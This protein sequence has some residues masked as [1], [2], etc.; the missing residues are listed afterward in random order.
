MRLLVAGD[1]RVDAGKTTFSTGLCASLDA[2]GFKPRAANDYWFDH[3][4]YRRSVH[5]GRLYG[6]DAR[7]LAAAGPGDRTPEDCNPVHRLWR[8]S[9]GPD[10]G[11][12]GATHRQFVLDRVGDAFVVNGDADVPADAREFLPLDDATTVTSLD[13]L[14]AAMERLHVDALDGVRG[15]IRDADRAVVESYGDIALPVRD[16][17]FDAVAIVD[18]GRVR[19]YDGDRYARA[20]EAVS[21]TPREGR[22]E[23]RVGDVLAYCDPLATVSLPA[24]A[25][26]VWTD[27]DAVAD[28]YEVAYEAV[29]T[30]ALS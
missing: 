28:A 19:V 11:L 12:V 25:S 22:L 2:P 26:D 13:A 18:P 6:K 29:V 24:L 23:E 15:T 10:T 3:D 20:C 4:D 30:A 21:G 16:L 17:A 9:P 14:N 8:P 1:A 5:D 27:P 7:R